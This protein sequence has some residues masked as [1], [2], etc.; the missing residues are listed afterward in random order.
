MRESRG[1]FIF[2]VSLAGLLLMTSAVS[3]QKRSAAPTP[4][5][6]PA[7]SAAAEQPAP[8]VFDGRTV[9]VAP[10]VAPAE[11]MAKVQAAFNRRLS[12][13]LRSYTLNEIISAA[14]AAAAEGRAV[15]LPTRGSICI[16]I[17]C[18]PLTI[19]IYRCGESPL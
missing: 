14:E 13:D 9:K 1:K 3:A 8:A 12:R 5:A 17:T 11:S 18:C 10:G 7:A 19:T 15:A 16:K 6:K 2:G 4:A